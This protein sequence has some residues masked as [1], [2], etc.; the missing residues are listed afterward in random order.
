MRVMVAVVGLAALVVAMGLA[1]AQEQKAEGVMGAIKDVIPG[2]SEQPAA[3]K[4]GEG[5]LDKVKG[6]ISSSDKPATEAEGKGLL[7]KAKSAVSGS[8]KPAT[9]AEGKGMLEKMKEM[10]PGCEKK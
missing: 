6:A 4:E 8:D 1:S 5:L 7:E 3:Q 2:G 9:E 10:V